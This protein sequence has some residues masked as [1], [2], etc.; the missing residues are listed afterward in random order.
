MPLPAGRP[1]AVVFPESMKSGNRALS[2]YNSLIRVAEELLQVDKVSTE[3]AH[4]RRQPDLGNR[5]YATRDNDLAKS[6]RLF[7][8]THHLEGRPRYD[9]YPGDQEGV[10]F[11]Y[12]VAEAKI[13]MEESGA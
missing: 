4:V 10:E 9:W 5:C 2:K 12:L 13:D 8:I 1:D 7:P 11:G 3:R 6:Y